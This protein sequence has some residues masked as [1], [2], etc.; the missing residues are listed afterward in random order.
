VS[1]DLA[2]TASWYHD[3]PRVVVQPISFHYL[4]IIT[5]ANWKLVFP[6]LKKTLTSSDRF[7]SGR[8]KAGSILEDTIRPLTLSYEI[9]KVSN[10]NIHEIEVY[11]F[12]WAEVT[13]HG[14]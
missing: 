2:F 13:N 4:H 9:L 8:E 14:Y 10:D 1:I 12:S 7:V 3:L 5:G 11:F 6:P